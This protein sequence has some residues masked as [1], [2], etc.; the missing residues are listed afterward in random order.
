VHYSS[1]RPP[2]LRDVCLHG[3]VRAV[4]AVASGVDGVEETKR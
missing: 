4:A 2:E 3:T 1:R